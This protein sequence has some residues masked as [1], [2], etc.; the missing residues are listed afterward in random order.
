ML[1][2]LPNLLTIGRVILI[3][4]LIAC[5]YIDAE[6]ARWAACAL[7][8]LAAITDY[9]DGVLARAW[10]QQSVFGRWLDPVADKLLVAAVLMMLVSADRAPIIP[11]VIILLREVLISGLREYMAE[12]RVGLP[13]SKLAKWKTTVQMVAVVFLLMGELTNPWVT[14]AV[15]GWWLLWAA[16]VLTIITGYD[17]VRIGLRQMQADERRRAN[18]TDVTPEG[19]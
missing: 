4:L 14:T 5:F 19:A 11:S 10:N 9:L 2:S 6:W 16:A 13:V 17:Y 8:L 18:S 1:T 12:A 7:F 3:P 15:I